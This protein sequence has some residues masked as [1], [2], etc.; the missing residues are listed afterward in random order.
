MGKAC[1]SKCISLSDSK[2]RNYQWYSLLFFDKKM[3]EN[4]LYCI[5][6]KE[7]DSPDKIKIHP[8]TVYNENGK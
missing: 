7:Q 1:L 5:Q 3:I 4:K 2:E 8:I 6:Y